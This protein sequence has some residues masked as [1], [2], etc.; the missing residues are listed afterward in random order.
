MLNSLDYEEM[1]PEP[2]PRGHTL[3]DRFAIQA[4]L[5]RGGFG[6]AY[7]AKD[8]VLEDLV[9]LKELA[10]E[11]SRRDAAGVLDLSAGASSPQLLRQRFLEEAR[12]LAKLNVRGV[13]PVRASFS[14]NGTAY[15]A[16]EYQ[17]GTETLE[18]VL[19]RERRLELT[20]AL[21]IFLALLDVLEAIHEK[22]ILHRDIKPSNILIS[23]S[24]QVTLIDFGAARGFFADSGHTHTVMYTPGYA[25]PEQLSERARRGPA[26]D[27]YALCAT[28]YHMLA[29]SPPEDAAARV[30]GLPLKPIRQLRPD[31]DEATERL[32]DRGLA[33]AYAE[34]P[35]TAEEVRE[36]L[37]G[38]DEPAEL[39]T[40][41]ALDNLLVRLKSFK[42]DRRS[43]PAC[44]GLLVEAR[45]LR[46]TAC[47]VCRKGTIRRRKIEESLCPVCRIGALREF[48]NTHQLSIC[49]TC[50][51]GRLVYRR[52]GLLSKEQIA[53]CAAC[54]EEYE[55]S[56]T[57]M[58][59]RSSGETLPLS[60]WFARSSRAERGAACR[61]CSAIFDELA[62]GRWKQ[63]DPKPKGRF[64]SL[65]PE[66][67]ARVAAGLEPG[68]GNA[69]CDACSADYYLESD[70]LTLLDANDD[71]YA[72]ARDYLGRQMTLEDA[73][74]LGVGKQSPNPG[75]VCDTCC[76]EFDIDANYLRLIQSDSRELVR[77]QGQPKTLEDWHRLGQ[78]L[79]TVDQEH[80]VAERLD[81]ELR[82]AYWKG[83]IGFDDAGQVAW[84]GE[85]TRV[86][87][88]NKGTLLVTSQ[89]ITF[90]GMLRKWKTPADAVLHANGR[91]NTL[92]LLL[93]GER[94]W[95]EFEVAPMTLYA[96]LQSGDRP[97]PL[98]A[99]DLAKR[100][101]AT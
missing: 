33:I 96:H 88:Q 15:Y 17:A 10:P 63:A 23:Q 4:V 43:C 75:Q 66:E 83:E 52:K 68:A 30:A 93:S 29:G 94:E 85:G 54:E 58:T 92:Q 27:L 45:P 11:G 48:D 7:L 71:P 3:S 64:V 28:L 77:Y 100:L 41:Q 40:F 89:E 20:G 2:L 36:L 59:L 13:L 50:S 62:D 12:T 21:D 84:K 24:G 101:D 61:E 90:G 86:E 35:Q 22:G 81:I 76:L 49:P 69:E 65:Y 56:G 9:A 51:K 19:Q 26:T 5:G 34:R 39:D 31:I 73:R 74:W 47:P 1:Q 97:I 78:G 82:E 98:T 57:T 79:P 46:R 91:S 32:L 37:T 14:E 18:K 70:A 53:H 60:D 95:L 25:P 8:V 16:T 42:Y 38:E 99:V 44:E 6:I 67:W 80:T 72:F 55:V 87:D